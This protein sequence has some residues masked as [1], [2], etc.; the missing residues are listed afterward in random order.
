M[1]YFILKLGLI[2]S[3]SWPETHYLTQLCLKLDPSASTSWILD[4]IYLLSYLAVCLFVCLFVF[5]MVSCRFAQGDWLKIHL[6][7]MAD[8]YSWDEHKFY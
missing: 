7:K 1:F 6:S 5:E 3:L 4:Y 2:L 8:N